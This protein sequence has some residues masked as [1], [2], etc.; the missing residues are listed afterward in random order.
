MQV[1]SDDMIAKQ[2][3]ARISRGKESVNFDAT[4]LELRPDLSIFLTD[5]KRRFPLIVECKIIDHANKKGVDLYCSK[6]IARFVDGDYAWTNREAI[7]LA[8]V[9][10]DSGVASKLTPHLAKS[11]T[12]KRDPLLTSA[13][14]SLRTDIHPTAHFSTHG[15][16]FRYLP[17]CNGTDPGEITL[18]HLW[19]K[20]GGLSADE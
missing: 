14:P 15:R 19:L 18:S 5:T 6:G 20:V 16:A 3:I 10:D 7:M 12:A 11:A 8:Y 4:K 1:C 2:I 13:H 17:D 9:R